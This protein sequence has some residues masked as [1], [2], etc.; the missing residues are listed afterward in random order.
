MFKGLGS[1]TS[2][3]GALKR[4]ALS[5]STSQLRCDDG[6]QALREMV[7]ISRLRIFRGLGK[8]V[9]LGSDLE[10]SASAGHEQADPRTL[11]SP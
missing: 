7:K 5:P 9:S 8:R 3:P 4:L 2:R 6:G 1:P 11:R 10:S